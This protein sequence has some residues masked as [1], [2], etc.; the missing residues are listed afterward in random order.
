MGKLLKKHLEIA[1][2]E[3]IE[4][5]PGAI[6]IT[7]LGEIHETLLGTISGELPGEEIQEYI[8]KC[9]LE[10]FL[11]LFHL[12]RVLNPGGSGRELLVETQ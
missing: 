3:V 2:E 10:E 6:I 8:V 7:S 4:A 12:E 9:F 5:I 11:V 1:L